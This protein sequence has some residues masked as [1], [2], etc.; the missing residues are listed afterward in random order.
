MLSDDHD[1]RRSGS[2][3]DGFSSRLRLRPKRRRRDA[4]P[5]TSSVG[6]AT[7]FRRASPLCSRIY[8][9]LC[10]SLIAPVGAS[11]ARKLQRF[12]STEALA[13]LALF[14]NPRSGP[15]IHGNAFRSHEL[16]VS[17]APQPPFRAD[18]GLTLELHSR[19]RR[20]H[21]AA[22]RSPQAR[23]RSSS[24]TNVFR[25]AIF[26]RGGRYLQRQASTVDV[27]DDMSQCTLLPRCRGRRATLLAPGDQSRGLRSLRTSISAKDEQGRG[28]KRSRGGLQRERRTR[29]AGSSARSGSLKT[30]ATAARLRLF[31]KID[32]NPIHRGDLRED[33]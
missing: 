25:D 21:C 5:T 17:T 11:D 28:T 7:V 29:L 9:R 10:T 27:F 18:L 32:G 8:P 2:R 26:V 22:P 12:R 3:D 31:S 33:R 1:C 13:A 14:T 20:S 6:S 19:V 23:G 16:A 24:A 30:M 15:P 4:R